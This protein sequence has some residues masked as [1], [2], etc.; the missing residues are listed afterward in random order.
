MDEFLGEWMYSL[1]L[2]LL[3][4]NGMHKERMS[5]INWRTLVFILCVYYLL[6]LTGCTYCCFY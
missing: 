5:G 4:G 2:L 1:F 3:F 6:L